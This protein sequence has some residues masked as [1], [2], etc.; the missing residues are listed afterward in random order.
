MDRFYFK[1]AGIKKLPQ[2]FSCFNKN[3]YICTVFDNNKKKFIKK[4]ISTTRKNV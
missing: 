3:N 2:L 4:T 1:I